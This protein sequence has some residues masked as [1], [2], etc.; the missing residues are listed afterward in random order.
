MLFG[1]YRAAMAPWSAT[2]IPDLAGRTVVVTGANSGLGWQTALELARHGAAVTMASRD[3]AKGAAALERLRAEVPDA[4]AVVRRL[5]L[6]DLAS[7]QA[8]ADDIVRDM[9]AVDIL[10]NN[11]GIMAV[12]Y[13]QTVDGFEAQFAT[14]HLGHFALTGRLLPVL[15]ARPGARV[16]TVSSTAAAFG[17]MDFDDLQSSRHYL[18]WMAYAQSKLANQLFAYELARRAEAA[19]AT[20]V[21]VAAHPGYA[22]T[23]LQTAAPTLAGHRVRAEMMRLSTVIFAQSDA[24]GALPQLYAATAPD[25]RNGEYFGPDRLFGQRGHPTRVTPPRQARAT[26][27]AHRLWTASEELTGVVYVFR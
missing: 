2:D 4:T 22:A 8:F 13:L 26:E 6:A 11:A 27:A 23:N 9:D 24:D 7:V 12:P 15:L 21:S 3:E 5:D 19:G 18:R 20:L 25:V 14:N 17:Q 1:V 10:V 16:V